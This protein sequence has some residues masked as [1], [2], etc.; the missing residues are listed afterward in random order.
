[1]RQRRARQCLV[2]TGSV[3]QLPQQDFGTFL[4]PRSTL[5]RALTVTCCFSHGALFT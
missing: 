3:R 5:F 2:L 4:P 1:V